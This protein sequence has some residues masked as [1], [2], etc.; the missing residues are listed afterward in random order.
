MRTHKIIGAVE[1][2]DDDGKKVGEIR[3]PSQRHAYAMSIA[4]EMLAALEDALEETE[5][6]VFRQR[7]IDLIAKANG[8]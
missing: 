5:S 1:F 3:G 7:L 4:P 2:L 6:P 8:E